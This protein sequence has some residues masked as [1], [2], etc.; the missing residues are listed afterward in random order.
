MS[1]ARAVGRR[2]GDDRGMV[3]LEVALAVPLLALVAVTMLG[4]G[5]LV[6]AELLVTD[7]A[8]D[9]ALQASR[10][11][12]TEAVARAVREQLPSASVEVSRGPGTT[13]ATVTAPAPVLPGIPALRVVHRASA[14]AAT[15][16]GLP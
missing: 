5:R 16:P 6:A 2:T 15:E 10:G 14:V 13:S 12:P 8:R 11:E 9:A 3:L 7:A 1:G 4:V